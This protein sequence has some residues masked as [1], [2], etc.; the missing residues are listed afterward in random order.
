MKQTTGKTALITGGA[1][2][3]GRAIALRLAEGGFDIVV[4]YHRSE[5]D[6]Q[7]VCGQIRALGREAMAIEADLTRIPEGVEA[8]ASG[9]ERVDVLVNNASICEPDNP[10]DVVERMRRMMAIHVEAPSLLCRA[11]GPKLREVQ[12]HVINMLDILAE[13]P[14]PR[15]A[16]Y[17]ASKAA[18]LNLTVSLA[19]ELAP[20]VTV[21]GIS[22]GVVQWPDNFPEESRAAY[23]ARVPLGRAG[24]AQ[25]VANLVHFL[26]TQGTYIT[27]QVIRVDGGR[28]L[29]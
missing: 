16:T 7:A 29:M 17:C 26:V 9:V 23:L 13:R 2:R 24:D 10:A 11:L 15:F 1:R 8:V 4:T 21:N 18:M 3:V 27:G 14:W 6:A 25:D 28:S 20:E 22:P 5:A 19:R 12:G